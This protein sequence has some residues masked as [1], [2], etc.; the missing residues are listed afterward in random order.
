V[1]EM[2]EEGVGE[3]VVEGEW[4]AECEGEG[5]GEGE[6]LMG[7]EA[8]VEVERLGDRVWEG[9]RVK[10]PLGVPEEHRD[11]LGEAERVKVGEGVAL[12]VGI[13]G[14]FTRQM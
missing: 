8:V 3:W 10:L 5:D 2:V 4:E 13:V 11:A 1:E 12:E 6:R 9:L 7:G 14:F